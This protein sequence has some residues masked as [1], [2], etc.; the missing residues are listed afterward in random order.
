MDCSF[1]MGAEGAKNN[2]KQHE[3]WASGAPRSRVERAQVRYRNLA[4]AARLQLQ[5]PSF[6]DAPL[7]GRLLYYGSGQT[8]LDVGVAPR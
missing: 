1:R 3:T 6:L 4:A 2:L 5:P 8:A 7:G